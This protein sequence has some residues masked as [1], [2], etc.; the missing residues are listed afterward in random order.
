MV[1][2]TY[3]QNIKYKLTKDET[4]RTQKALGEGDIPIVAVIGAVLGLQAGFIAIFLG[5]LFAIIPSIYN[6][7]FKKDIE[8]PFIPYLSLGFFAEY[9]FLFSKGF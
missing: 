3:I 4:L 2:L 8:T 1:G 5:A 6:L 9:I 7:I